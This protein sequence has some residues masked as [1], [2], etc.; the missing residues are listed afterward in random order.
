M[1]PRHVWYMLL[2][3]EPQKSSSSPCT[4]ADV[5]AVLSCQTHI[6]LGFIK[7]S[8]CIDFF[9]LMHP[10]KVSIRSESA[11]RGFVMQTHSW[12]SMQ[13]LDR[14]RLVAWG[15]DSLMLS[16]LNAMW[17]PRWK[18]VLWLLFGSPRSA[19]LRAHCEAPE[20]S[21]SELIASIFN[22]SVRHHDPS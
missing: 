2:F 8:M 3:V 10:Q 19:S 20:G 14:A 4:E 7:Q 22:W 6:K 12:F 5:C 13:Y 17:A 21:F 11:T 1:S 9:C 15:G 18:G 16:R